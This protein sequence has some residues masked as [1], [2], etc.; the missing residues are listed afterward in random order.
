MWKDRKQEIEIIHRRQFCLMEEFFWQCH[1]L[2]WR[3]RIQFSI[4]SRRESEDGVTSG[5]ENVEIEM[6]C[7][8]NKKM[9]KMKC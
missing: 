1:I 2:T 7:I 3:F 6:L 5:K 8:F 4:I 9:I